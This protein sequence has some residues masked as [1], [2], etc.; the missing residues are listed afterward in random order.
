MQLM[1]AKL[2][3][4]PGGQKPMCPAYTATLKREI[5]SLFVS[6]CR[7]LQRRDEWVWWIRVEEQTLPRVSWKPI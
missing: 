3:T 7:L 1:S 2:M 6:T 4:Q 5:A